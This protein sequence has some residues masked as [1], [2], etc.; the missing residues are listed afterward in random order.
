ML[1][2]LS[3]PFTPTGFSGSRLKAPAV[4]AVV[5]AAEAN[6][7]FRRESHRDVSGMNVSSGHFRIFG[8]PVSSSSA[9]EIRH[10]TPAARG[11][12]QPGFESET[13]GIEMPVFTFWALRPN[14][15]LFTLM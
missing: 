12:I 15:T 6:R 1:S 5:A 10:A 14:V 13:G 9:V 4:A 7:S 2:T 3:L 11:N 8:R